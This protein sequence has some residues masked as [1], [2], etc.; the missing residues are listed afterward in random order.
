MRRNGRRRQAEARN[1]IITDRERTIPGGA[2]PQPL[3]PKMR[4]LIAVAFSSIRLAILEDV[5]RKRAA[6]RDAPS[7]GE[8]PGEA[9]LPPMR[10]GGGRGRPLAAAAAAADAAAASL[11]SLVIICTGDVRAPFQPKLG[12]ATRAH[13]KSL[14]VRH[15]HFARLCGRWLQQ[16]HSTPSAGV[17]KT[18]AGQVLESRLRLALPL[19]RDAK[20]VLETHVSEPGVRK[21]GRAPHELPCRRRQGRLRR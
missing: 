10:S 9:G 20:T 7:S 11:R 19:Q 2:F 18:L 8:A 21:E 1:Y 12:R 4:S 14:A 13:L 6:N 17:S 5:L 16:V 3:L 15:K